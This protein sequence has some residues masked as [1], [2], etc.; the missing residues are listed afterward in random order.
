MTSFL[1]LYQ[2]MPAPRHSRN[3]KTRIPYTRKVIGS[4]EAGKSMSRQLTANSLSSAIIAD[5]YN[6]SKMFQTLR[7]R[8]KDCLDIPKASMMANT[9]IQP[10]RPVIIPDAYR[11]DTQPSIP[12]Q[13]ITNC[14]LHPSIVPDS[15]GEWVYSRD[16]YT[17]GSP[18]SI[19]IA[20]S[21]RIQ[22]LYIANN[23]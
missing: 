20:I 9:I 7:M 19:H 11:R 18:S 10:Y 8:R 4:T 21:S 5:G 22:P 13:V 2:N 12:R 14:I 15:I 16:Y 23:Q 3:Y 17:H 1:S 6:S